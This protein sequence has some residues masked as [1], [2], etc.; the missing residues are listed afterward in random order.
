MRL[1]AGLP[2]AGRGIAAAA[3]GSGLPALRE[4]ATVTLAILSPEGVVAGVESAPDP[5]PAIAP[6]APMVAAPPVVVA[7]PQIVPP[8]VENDAIVLASSYR[9]RFYANLTACRPT[10]PPHTP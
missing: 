1:L 6:S 8:P 3:T 4:I 5:A 2:P 9:P 7:I 10:Y